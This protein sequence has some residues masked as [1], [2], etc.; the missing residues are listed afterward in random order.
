MRREGRFGGEKCLSKLERGKVEGLPLPYQNERGTSWLG[1]TN[2]K[3]WRRKRAHAQRLGAQKEPQPGGSASE[4]SQ[5]SC[6]PL[7]LSAH[8]P[9]LSGSHLQK[10]VRA[11]ESSCSWQVG[12]E[13]V[14]AALAASSRS[15][16]YV[17][18]T[19]NLPFIPCPRGGQNMDVFFNTGTK[20]ENHDV[21]DFSKL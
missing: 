12:L 5:T 13:T 10:G 17:T 7:W 8:P 4:K 21:N 16:G 11:Q 2:R 9:P 20:D 18:V 19:L 3:A 14:S 6:L 1:D 15:F